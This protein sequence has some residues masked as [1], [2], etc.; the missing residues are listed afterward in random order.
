M[1]APEE[2]RIGNVVALDDEVGTDHTGTML[3][4]A[5]TN[6]KVKRGRETTWAYPEDLFPVFLTPAWIEKMDNEDYKFHL[7]PDATYSLIY[8]YNDGV[9]LYLPG[10]R[11]VHQLQNLYHALTGQDLP[12]K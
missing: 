12:L 5:H 9:K 4:I 8:D 7:Q 6:M 2:L 1:I 3:E 11:Y 10:C